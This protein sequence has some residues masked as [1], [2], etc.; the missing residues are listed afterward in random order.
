MQIK[1]IKTAEL[2]PYQNNAKKHPKEQIDLLVR[3]IKR[4]GFTSPVLIDEEKN[5]IAG[6]GRLEALKEMGK[7]TAPCVEMKGLT[8]KE[9]MALRLADN[10]IAEMG[11]WDIDLIDEELEL[12]DADLLELTGFEKKEKIIEEKPEVDFS[13]ELLEEHNYIV[14]YFNNSVD[15]LQAQSLLDLKTVSALDSKKGFLKMGVGRVM[16]GAKALNKIANEN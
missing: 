4:F 8:K 11:E 2:K 1:Q 10:K 6:H 15:W 13:E 16:N 9:I 5:V 14:L 3:N 12:L 7:E